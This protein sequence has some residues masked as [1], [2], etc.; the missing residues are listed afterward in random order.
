[1]NYKTID[2]LHWGEETEY[3]DGLKVKAVEGQHWGARLPWNKEMES[4]SLLLSKNGVNIFFGADT[5]YTEKIQQQLREVDIEL[6]IM[7]IGATW[8]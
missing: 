4:N 2:E 1:M 5:G 8:V 7:G 6:A 3:P